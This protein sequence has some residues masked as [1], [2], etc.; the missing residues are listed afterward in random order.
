MK[1][2][3]KFLRIISLFALIF[4]IEV[5]ASS[6]EYFKTIDSNNKDISN[7]T[8]FIAGD[9]FTSDNQVDGISFQAGNKI[10]SLG[11]MEYGILAGN[12]LII[13]NNVDKD[14]FIAG[15]KIVINKETNIGKDLFIAGND[16]IINNNINGN[17]FVAA[18]NIEINSEIIN[19]DVNLAASNINIS[20]NTSIKGTLSYN[21]SSI[22][23]SGNNI[24]D[25]KEYG[26]T[27]NKKIS[28]IS[29]IKSIFI[30]ILSL[31]IVGI[32]MNY[33]FPGLFDS[34]K[35][36]NKDY[37]NIIWNGF[38]MLFLIP[39]ISLLSL[40]TIIGIPIGIISVLIYGILIYTS[41]IIAGSKLGNMISK[42]ENNYYK[43]TIGII[44]I[45]ILS[46]VPYLNAITTIFVIISALGLYYN[47]FKIKKLA[48]YKK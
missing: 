26:D 29:K 2:V 15:N 22:F 9:E 38:I 47:Y 18:K 10:T 6:N 32:L 5:K 44:I 25:I 46:I 4:T 12:E 8:T 11:K 37:I 48:L 42:N 1:N 19:G 40:I 34:I 43:T 7:H 28:Y 30:S 23:H 39:I 27:K 33:L 24:K 16:V 45:K 31:I 35:K 13:N 17:I 36:I 20:N 21:K 3:K 14:L 41:T